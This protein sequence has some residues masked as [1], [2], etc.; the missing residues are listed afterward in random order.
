[1][2]VK[3]RWAAL[4][5]V[6]TIVIEVALFILVGNWIGFGWAVLAILA[7]MALGLVLVRTEG[8][9]AW[10]RFRSVTAAGERPGPHLTRSLVGLVGAA[11]LL[12]PGYLTAA[13]GLLLFLPPVRTVAGHGLTAL[14]GRRLASGAMGDLFGPRQVKVKAGR[15]TRVTGPD[16][17]VNDTEP[18]E[19]E[20]IDPR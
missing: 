7:L 6:L 13:I 12:V 4:A 5:V 3:T 9:R 17:V 2:L 11:L 14:A 16:A 8:I 10:Q 19:G 18:L 20:I 15:P 1:M